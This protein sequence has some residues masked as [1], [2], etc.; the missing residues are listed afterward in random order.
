MSEKGVTHRHGP[1]SKRNDQPA[2]QECEPKFTIK[3][4]FHGKKLDQAIS[5]SVVNGLDIVP[6]ALSFAAIE[7]EL[8]SK[9]GRE[10][11]LKK[12]LDEK[13]KQKYDFIIIDTP[14]LWNDLNKHALCCR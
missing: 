4:V 9:I 2:P 12:V 13:I 5:P 6:S 1:A 11:I 7:S 8:I 10:L 3:D 14:H